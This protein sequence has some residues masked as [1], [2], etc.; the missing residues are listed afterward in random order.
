[1]SRD[2]A[3]RRDPQRVAVVRDLL[4]AGVRAQGI[5][6]LGRTVGLELDHAERA[7]RDDLVRRA[8]VEPRSPKM[9]AS[10]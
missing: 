7:A 6:R 3:A 2:A 9:N 4:D 8:D 5:R 10:R 1:M